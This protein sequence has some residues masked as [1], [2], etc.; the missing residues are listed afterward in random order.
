M[1]VETAKRVPC[2]IGAF[3]ELPVGDALCGAFDGDVFAAALVDIAIH[4]ISGDVEDLR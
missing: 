1:H 2:A 3:E 4:E